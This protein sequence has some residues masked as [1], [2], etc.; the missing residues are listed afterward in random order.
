M[1]GDSVA[2]QAGTRGQPCATSGTDSG[3]RSGNAL[4]QSNNS[5]FAGVPGESRADLVLDV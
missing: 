3:S 2:C 4:I 5:A 1:P